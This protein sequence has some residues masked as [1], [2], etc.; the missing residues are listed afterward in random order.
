MVMQIAI[1]TCTW[2]YSL[3]LL[4]IHCDVPEQWLLQCPEEAY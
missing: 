4:V 3:V 2:F 1:G